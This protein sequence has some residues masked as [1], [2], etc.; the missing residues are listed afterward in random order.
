MGYQLSAT[1]D[2]MVSYEYD[3][4]DKAHDACANKTKILES[5][6]RTIPPDQPGRVER[7]EDGLKTWVF[8]PPKPRP[9]AVM[10]D[11]KVTKDK[12][13]KPTFVY[14]EVDAK[15]KTQYREKT[16]ASWHF[17][18]TS[19]CPEV[20]QNLLFELAAAEAYADRGLRD[21]ASDLGDYDKKINGKIRQT[22]TGKPAGSGQGGSSAEN[23]PLAVNE[24]CE[25]VR[26][27]DGGDGSEM[28][29]GDEAIRTYEEQHARACKPAIVAEATVRHEKEHVSQCEGD[30]ARYSPTGNKAKIQSM[31]QSELSAY[32]VSARF[33]LSFL[34]DFC[35]D[36][37]LDLAGPRQRIGEL[38]AFGSGW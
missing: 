37:G 9:Q 4:V 7:S 5:H 29:R 11:G 10:G 33:L 25:I 12:I 24:D 20:Y 19:P 2:T 13:E 30:R 26:P 6:S 23:F 38:E 14:H 32:L 34:E 28:L 17:V 27:A 16:T 1:H 21:F 8:A 36:E 3:E 15:E 31:G 22:F 35:Q 18:A